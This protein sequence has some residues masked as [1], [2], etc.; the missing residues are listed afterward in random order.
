MVF[1]ATLG[2]GVIVMH[3]SLVEWDLLSK[4]L[5]VPSMTAVRCDE[6]V[7]RLKFATMDMITFA[8]KVINANLL[9]AEANHK[10]QLC[11]FQ[12]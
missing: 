4:G 11:L 3:Q 5:F 8:D 6:D 9:L 7:S 10:N 2:D 1:R 12:A